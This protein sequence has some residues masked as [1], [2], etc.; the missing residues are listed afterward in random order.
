MRYQDQSLAGRIL[1]MLA[2]QQG[3]SRA[4]YA[5]QI[6]G[7]LPFLLAALNNPA[8]QN[9]VADA[10]GTFLQDPK[11][12]TVKLAPKTPV[13]GAEI[14]SIAGSSPQTLPDR[15]NASVTANTAE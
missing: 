3:I 7:A 6:S 8:F 11:S 14:M 5:K 9:Q 13:T 4:D 12:L 2:K 10:V 1:D 15:L